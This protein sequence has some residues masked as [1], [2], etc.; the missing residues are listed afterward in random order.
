MG[1]SVL[2]CEA[3]T[4]RVRDPAESGVNLQRRMTR[5]SVGGLLLSIPLDTNGADSTL[6]RSP[7]AQE[8]LGDEATG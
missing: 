6:W 4:G 5:H 3:P 8:V 7:A 2:P 1:L